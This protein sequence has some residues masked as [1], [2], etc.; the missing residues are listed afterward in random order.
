VIGPDSSSARV[1]WIIATLL[2]VFVLAASTFVN[3]GL[4]VFYAVP[5][6][7]ASWW[8][9]R[10]AGVVT[11]IGAAGVYAFGT[12]FHHV[13][14]FGAA[15]VIRLVIYL[16]VALLV[17]LARERLASL[18]PSAEELEAIRAA[19][20]PADLPELTGL[21]AAAA[22]VPSGL[23][24]AG[25]F[26]LLADAPD[27]ASV[28]IVGD[29]AGRGAAAARLATFVRARFAAFAASTSDPAELLTLAN[30]ALVDRPG[31]SGEL[32]SAVCL[33][34]RAGQPTFSWAIAGQ[35]P[36]LRLP[37]LGELSAEAGEL[38]LG[39]DADLALEN[40][41]ST[42]APGE[43]L[44]VYTDGATG[45]RRGSEALGLDGLR[46][47]L[48]PRGELPAPRL[49]SEVREA[50]LA[51]ADRPIRDDLCVL[52]LRPEAGGTR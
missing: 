34:F 12:L 49:A 28:A 32:V 17:A 10:R 16:A 50:I 45:V 40:T 8:F 1:A 24:I 51:W 38:P 18:E 22:F 25:D 33:R 5:V 31:A 14:Q 7:L 26:F 41:E 48:A 52:V 35:P 44:V 29:A 4:N 30:T 37:G 27:G 3:A 36:P 9:G 6:G 43:G 47:I 11:A 21:D 23:G 15:L 19:L 39:A 20:T 46:G 13:H 42:I 2:L